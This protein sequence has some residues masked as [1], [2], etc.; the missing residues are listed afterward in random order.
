MIARCSTCPGPSFSVVPA[1]G[2]APCALLFLGAQPGKTE[3]HTGVPYSGL[4]G[5]EFNETYLTAAGMRREDVAVGNTMNCWSGTTRTP[6]AKECRTC[7]L[8]HLP[9]TL[10]RV[11]PEVL[12]TMGAGAQG[13]VDA[14]VRLEMHRGRPLW[15]TLLGGVWEGWV[16]PMY[17][18]ALGMRDTPRMSQLLEDFRHLGQWVRGEWKPP[19]PAERTKDYKLVE[20]P[21]AFAFGPSNGVWH[22]HIPWCAVDTETDG[23]RPWSVQWSQKTG[24][25]RMA[26]ATDTESLAL[27]AALLPTVEVR[28]HNAPGDFDTL[29]KMGIHIAKWRDTMQE[30]YHL[31]SLPQGLKPLA[32]R[33]LGV[34]MRSWE[35]V[36]W[37]AS[38]AAAT[39][40]I[41]DAIGLA[42]T[43]L[44]NAEVTYLKM[45]VCGG[46]GKRGRGQPCRHCGGP[47]GFRR[48]TYTPG[49]AQQILRHVLTHT[50]G[51][52]ED[53]KPYDPWKAMGRFRDEGLRGKKAE[54]W[55]WDF[56][57]QELGRMPILSIANA[58]MADA[59]T[60]AVGDAD[61]TGRVA[62]ELERLR[63]DARWEVP[64]E[65]WD[66]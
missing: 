51:T 21:A 35:D 5:D 47:V 50:A 7:A 55:E 65:D 23:G 17:E 18:P 25:G 45:G 4:A 1:V 11:R 61:M 40:W 30:A 56:L 32:Y 6:T 59:I 43:N 66:V 15:T 28:L 3:N 8:T 31:C 63:G 48:T 37:P 54:G 16:F 62:V 41:E 24:Q 12:V 9:R 26:L 33:L 10:D 19:E 22:K 39:G 20:T 52:V 38:V 58:P 60:Y 34:E 49:A 36:V 13:V 44:A 27:L 53:E 57:E 29:A 64:R 42:E 14:R 46:C 2:P